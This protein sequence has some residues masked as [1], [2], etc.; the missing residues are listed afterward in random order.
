MWCVRKGVVDLCLPMSPL[1]TALLRCSKKEKKK[2]R[3]T[4]QTAVLVVTGIVITYSPSYLSLFLFFFFF[5]VTLLSTLYIFL[6]T[7]LFFGPVSVLVFLCIQRDA[8]RRRCTCDPLPQVEEGESTGSWRWH[9]LLYFLLFPVR[10]HFYSLWLPGVSC[11]C[12][13]VQQWQE[14]CDFVFRLWTTR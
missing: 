13:I 5:Y 7:S 11:H 3:I 1:G 4:A 9:V 8:H 10:T 6:F 2:S 12:C 14:R